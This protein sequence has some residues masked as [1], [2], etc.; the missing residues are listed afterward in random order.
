MNTFTLVASAV[1]AITFLV[2]GALKLKEPKSAALALS[3]F[4]LVEM[5]SKTLGYL[6]GAVELAVAILLFLE[7][8][9]TV[10]AVSAATL[11]WGFTILIARA[12]R[13][14]KHFACFC[15]GDDSGSVSWQTVLRTSALAGLA[16]ALSAV[17]IRDSP[18]SG[19]ALREIEALISGTALVAIAFIGARVP[20]LRR[21][22][23]Q[24]MHPGGERHE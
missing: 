15:F 20:L 22:N 9:R 1:L 7:P 18:E 14:G 24:F 12:V 8:L 3:D 16:T 6:A 19:S 11:L 21:L 10:G 17:L 13:A 23:H 2:A 5:P 4:G